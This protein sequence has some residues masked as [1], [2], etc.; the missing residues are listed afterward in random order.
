MACLVRY[1]GGKKNKGGYGTGKYYIRVWIPQLKKIKSIPTHTENRKEA[2]SIFKKI[3]SIENYRRAEYEGYK[4][5]NIQPEDNWW[6]HPELG[7]EYQSITIKKAVNEYIASCRN[8]ISESTVKTYELALRDL[9]NAIK[10]STRITELNKKSYDT[11]LSYLESKF[12]KTTVNI[13][14]RGIRAFLMWIVENEYLEKLPFKVKMLKLK[15]RLPK[16]I[17]PEEM[18]RIYA[19]TDDPILLSI[20]RVYESTGMRLSEL[21]TSKLEGKFL[22]IVGKGNKERIVPLPDILVND[23]MIAKEANYHTD[24]ITRA[25]TEAKRKAKIEGN[26][27]LHS[28]RHTFAL[29][30]LVELGDIYLVKKLLGHSTV[31]VT[32]VYTKFPVEYLKEVFNSKVT[33]N[34][35][36]VSA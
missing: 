10:E 28:L 16:F 13:R 18:K 36:Q 34:H 12:N 30:M 31:T 8:R 19:K 23:Y 27:T 20:F 33:E 7:K 4:V 17:T 21:K 5:F 22:R 24:R 1:P 15:D 3:Q 9:K 6:D 25:F 26:K 14:L 2:L 29:R 11:I 32:E 35:I